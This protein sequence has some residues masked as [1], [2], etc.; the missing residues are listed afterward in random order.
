MKDLFGQEIP[1]PKKKTRTFVKQQEDNRIVRKPVQ[2]D[3]KPAKKFNPE[4]ELEGVGEQKSNEMALGKEVVQV[5]RPKV[6]FKERVIRTIPVIHAN[7]KKGDIW[8]AEFTVEINRVTRKLELVYKR[9][10]DP[11][12]KDEW[13][14]L[15]VKRD[16]GLKN[17]EFDIV[18]IKLI[19]LIGK[20]LSSNTGYKEVKKKTYE[21]KYEQR[22]K[23]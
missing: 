13:L 12:N 8:L 16:L 21:T 7:C 15:K 17:N 9:I 14:R 18:G 10:K 23:D 2:F 6:K 11:I 1:E 3:N 4:D 5:K 22:Y 19:K 20:A